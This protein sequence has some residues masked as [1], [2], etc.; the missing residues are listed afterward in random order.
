[1]KKDTVSSFQFFHSFG[2]FSVSD[3]NHNLI[4]YQ[5][6]CDSYPAGSQGQVDPEEEGA[7]GGGDIQEGV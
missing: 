6:I 4:W 5:F 1:M 7:D 2:R 3:Q